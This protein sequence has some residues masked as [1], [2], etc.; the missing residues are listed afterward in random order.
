MVQMKD[1]T[2]GLVTSS[3]IVP[4]GIIKVK[5]Y[6]LSGWEMW[7]LDC[8]LEQLKLYF[9]SQAAESKETQ[10][11]CAKW[12]YM[13]LHL[14]HSSL[15]DWGSGQHHHEEPRSV[16]QSSSW[17]RRLVW[18]QE[19]SISAAGVPSIYTGISADVIYSTQAGFCDFWSIWVDKISRRKGGINESICVLHA[20]RFQPVHR[21]SR[22][23]SSAQLVNSCS[24]VQAFIICNIVLMKGHG[25]VGMIK[26]QPPLLQ[27]LF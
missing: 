20:A 7:M 5:F 14:R 24:N 1:F 10:W 13:Y 8:G 26:L 11:A 6:S 9:F 12:C 3:I 2:S 23:L 27:W 16:L 25:K 4:L 17:E 18:K 22:S 19:V 21:P 15:L